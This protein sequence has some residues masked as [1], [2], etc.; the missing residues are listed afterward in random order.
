MTME[1]TLKATNMWSH[2]KCQTIGHAL[3]TGQLQIQAQT[4]SENNARWAPWRAIDSD[5][6]PQVVITHRPHHCSKDFIAE[7]RPQRPANAAMGCDEGYF[8]WSKVNVA[9]E[10]GDKFICSVGG[11]SQQV[12]IKNTSM[13]MKNTLLSGTTKGCTKT[14]ETM[15]SVGL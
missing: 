7:K 8:S 13:M 9:P 14:T 11:S 1:D 10:I 3:A 2:K 5:H 12:W 4:S 15:I 6:P